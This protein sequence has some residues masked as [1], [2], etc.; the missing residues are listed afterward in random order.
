MLYVPQ[1]T[2]SKIRPFL[3]TSTVGAFYNPAVY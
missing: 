3:P 2:I 1:N